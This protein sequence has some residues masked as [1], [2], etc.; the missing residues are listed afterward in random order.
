MPLFGSVAPDVGN[1]DMA[2]CAPG[3]CRGAKPQSSLSCPGEVLKPLF[4]FDGKSDTRA[5]EAC[6][7]F[8]GSDG[9]K[10]L[11]AAR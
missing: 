7:H 1:G 9:P 11:T 3:D 6:R 4:H 10:R 2:E 8:G 5:V